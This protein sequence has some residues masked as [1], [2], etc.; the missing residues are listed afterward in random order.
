MTKYPKI[1]IDENNTSPVNMMG[2]HTVEQ[3]YDFMHHTHNMS[4]IVNDTGSSGGTGINGK[5]AYEVWLSLGNKG[6]EQD[7]INS[8]KGKDGI[9]GSWVDVD[10]TDTSNIMSLGLTKDEIEKLSTKELNLTLTE[11]RT[12]DILIGMVTQDEYSSP[13]ISEV[14][15]SYLRIV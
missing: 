14:K 5:S 8:L 10:I 2:N 6:S 1:I 15:V 11:N 12:L 3:Y 4:D 7:F 9:D 13:S